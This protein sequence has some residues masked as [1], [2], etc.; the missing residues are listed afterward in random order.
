MKEDVKVNKELLTRSKLS[1][2]FQN[3][4]MKDRLKKNKSIDLTN[5]FAIYKLNDGY[6]KIEPIDRTKIY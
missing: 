1:N 2:P 6:D 4:L 5:N 3:Q